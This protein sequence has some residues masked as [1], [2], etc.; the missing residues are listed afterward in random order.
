MGVVN[1]YMNI[2][3]RPANYHLHIESAPSVREY[4]MLQ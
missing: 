1:G 4:T 3:H 2:V